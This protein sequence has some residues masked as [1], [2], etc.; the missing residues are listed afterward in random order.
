[1]GYK[2]NELWF[3]RTQ[4]LAFKDLLKIAGR[5]S[6][7]AY[8]EDELPAAPKILD[9]GVGL[10]YETA[11][12]LKKGAKVDA[13]DVDNRVLELLESKCA[14]YKRQLKTWNYKVPFAQET[15]LK[16]KYDLVIVSNVLH[17]LTYNDILICLEQLFKL[18]ADNGFILL[19]AHTKDH[20][21]NDPLHPKK[22]NYHYFFQSEDIGLL[23][24]PDSF[25]TLYLSKYF[26]IYNN[27]ECDIFGYDA[28][29]QPFKNGLTA[30]MRKD[31]KGNA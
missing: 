6:D 12:Y 9:V 23:F 26:R 28:K 30:I 19:R 18:V 31:G 25:Q 3:K 10:G 20:P 7:F 1:M 27:Q 4:S 29:N 24:P 16:E 21:Y 14:G 15:P 17:F 22:A 2:F 13:I 5:Y 8:F 11:Y